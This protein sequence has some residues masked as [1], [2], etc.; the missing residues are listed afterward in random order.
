MKLLTENQ[1]DPTTNRED[2][3]A[4]QEDPQK[5]RTK[6]KNFQRNKKISIRFRYKSL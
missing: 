2:S 1:E 4:Y 5:T 3:T 6:A